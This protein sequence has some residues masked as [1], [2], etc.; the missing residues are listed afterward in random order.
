MYNV[1]A[2]SMWLIL[3]VFVQGNRELSYFLGGNFIKDGASKYKD[4][5]SLFWISVGQSR[6]V[7]NS[8]DF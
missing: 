5:R 8:L 6:L 1:F 2:L 3:F 4:I 7:N